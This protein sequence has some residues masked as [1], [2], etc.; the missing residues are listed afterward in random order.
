M[1]RSHSKAALVIALVLFGAACGPPKLTSDATSDADSGNESTSSSSSSSETSTT[2]TDSTQ[3]G[4]TDS[5]ETTDS[6]GPYPSFVPEPDVVEVFECDP[7]AQ[8]CPDGQKCVPYGSTGGNWDANKCV[9]V[10]GDQAPGEPCTYEGVVEA[11]DDCDATSHCWDLQ[12]VEGEAVG[13]CHAFC[14]GTADEPECPEASQ[15]LIGGCCINLCIP[16]CDPILQDCGEGLACYWANNGFNCIFT[17]QDIPPGEPCGF[18]NDCIVGSGCTTAEALP[19]CVGA[20]CCSPFCELGA[21]DL[22]CEVLPG[23][24]CV[25]FFEQGMAPPGYEDVGVCILPP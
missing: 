8:D 18:I 6:T 11:L 1:N 3:T 2:S 21:G 4:T 24:T 14:T 25:P 17:T 10:L 12:D 7:F 20:A 16:T 13:I 15:C 5:T 23:T 9:P 22:T 19:N